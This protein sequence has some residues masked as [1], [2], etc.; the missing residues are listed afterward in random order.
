MNH[1]LRRGHLSGAFLD[2]FEAEPLAAESPLWT[3]PDVI[4]TPHSAGQSAGNAARTAALFLQNLGRWL[5][6]AP[7]HHRA[8][9]AD[10]L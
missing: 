3:L 5:V 7:L 10:G 9:P 8:S 4:V 6:G 2:V 1:A